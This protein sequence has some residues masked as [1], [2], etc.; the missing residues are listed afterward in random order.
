MKKYLLLCLLPILFFGG[1]FYFSLDRRPL[2]SVVMPTYNRAD[3]LPRAI[4]SILNQTY[5]KF[6]FIIVDDASTDGSAEL[7]K[8]YANIDTR[9]KILTNEKNRGISY[10]R[11]RGT[12]FAKGKYVAIMD[13]DDY[14]EPTRLEKH[15]AYLEKNKDVMA[16]NSTYLELGKEIEGANNWIP[17]LRFD[18]IFHLKNYYTNLALFR[19]DFVRKHNIRYNEN[20][21]SSE[22]Y[23]FWAQIFVK[24]GKLRM[25]NEPLIKLRRHQ[26]NSKEYYAHIIKN[27][28]T[29][30]DRLLRHF[31]VQE[32]EK[33]KTDC[34]RLSAMLEV[35]NKT[36]KID[37]YSFS[38]IYIRQCQGVDVPKNGLYI[39][40]TDWIDY[41]K[42]TE[43]KNVYVRLKNNDKYKV[44]EV[45]KNADGRENVFIIEAPDKTIEIFH[46]QKDNTLTLVYK[47]EKTWIEKLLDY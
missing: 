45:R 15:V 41:L 2:V 6:E 37:P 28:R 32:P 17:P 22:D 3:L 40:H 23:D 24:G 7:L 10:S 33:L 34:E 26:T 27:S 13:S 31:G 25:L 47:E 5:D 14:S 20:L 19:T 12:D 39:K 38:L 36:K 35:N 8:N 18:I 4:N 21:I 42:P 30:S 44:L 46:K 11:N 29:I 9:I 43:E 1:I 16:L